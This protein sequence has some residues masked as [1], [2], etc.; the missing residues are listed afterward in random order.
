M[1]TTAQT[2]PP[3][4]PTFTASELRSLAL[5][6]ASEGF[7]D[8]EIARRLEVSTDLVARWIEGG[9]HGIE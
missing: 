2:S 8:A 3:A 6:L 7:S 5:T 1:N 4:Q 9:W